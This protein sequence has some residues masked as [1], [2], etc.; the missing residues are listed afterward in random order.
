[1]ENT[2]VCIK[3]TQ[4]F[5]EEKLNKGLWLV[6]INA[7][8]IPPHVGMLFN[9]R[10]YS[11]NV[12]GQEINIRMQALLKRIRIQKIKAV[13]V[14][15]KPHPVFSPDYLCG[16]FAILVQKHPRVNLNGIT[17]FTPV[18]SFFTENYALCENDLKFLYHLFPQLYAQDVIS[19][20]MSVNLEEN[21]TEAE[22]VFRLPV[23]TNEDIEDKLRTVQREYHL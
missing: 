21:E 8:R 14:Q 10:Y 19:G 22:N 16:Y 13:F 17:C 11:L 3:I 4:E 1:M 9:G 5:T 7:K 20:A 18:R 2:Q 15:L 23:Y 6:L 12:T